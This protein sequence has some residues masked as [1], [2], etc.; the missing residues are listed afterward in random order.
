MSDYMFMLESHLS[1]DQNR[2]LNEVQAA[3]AEA[4]I[5]V[6]L[7][8]GAMRDMLGGFAVRDLDFTVEGNALKLARVLAKKTGAQ[9]TFTDQRRK[10]VEMEFPGRVTAEIGMARRESYAKPGAQP[11]VTPATVHEDLRRR[12]FTINAVALSLNR[13]SRGL[14]ID[15]SNGVA[16]L[17]HKELRA[18]HSYVLYDDPGRILR[19][20]RLRVRL[21]F[22]VEERTAQQY[23]N[24]RAEGLEQRIPARRL[25]EE[26][27]EIAEDPNPAEVLRA[28]AEE[29]L[30]SL[31]SPSLVAGKLNLAALTK[32]HKAR[33]LIPYGVPFP[34]NNLPLFLSLVTEKLNAREKAALVRATGLRPSDVSA[35]HKL[36][37]RAKRLERELKSPKLHKPFDLYQAL[38]AVPGELALYVFVHSPVRLVQDR[39]HNYFQK[40]LPAAI[41]V[42][43]Q[44]VIAQGAE[45]GTAKFRKLK[46][47]LIEA[48]LNVR[49]KHPVPE[50]PGPPEP[51]LQDPRLARRLDARQPKVSRA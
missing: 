20:V 6:F 13:A 49:H 30:L 18:V 44:E 25:L 51:E 31:F 27:R 8:G 24:V 46:N 40:Y 5:S 48:R 10:C 22:A 39:I 12:D 42:S 17:E 35:W 37:A 47:G 3:A 26:L 45:P 16:D 21:S 2:V 9:I 36:E 28:L 11:Q 50:E 29:K 33:Q 1:P 41:E 15:P 19:L 43:D 32:L 14:L 38:S 23:Q 34:V 7:T 4:N